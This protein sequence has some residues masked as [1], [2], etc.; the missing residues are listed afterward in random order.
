VGAQLQPEPPDGPAEELGFESP[1]WQ[2]LTTI[3]GS[4]LGVAAL[5]AP[6]TWWER[7]QLAAPAGARANGW[8]GWAATARSLP[9]RAMAQRVQAIGARP[10]ARRHR[11]HKP[12]RSASRLAAAA[13]AGTLCPQPAQQLGTLR[14]DSTP[15]LAQPT[16]GQ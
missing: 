15:F 9:P 8:R 3:L 10:V 2:D 4:L 5:G 11:A 7:R 14:R 6:R 12:R 13:G 16:P 1:S